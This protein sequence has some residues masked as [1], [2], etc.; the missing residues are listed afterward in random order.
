MVCDVTDRAS[1]R[2]AHQQAIS[3]FGKVLLL[4]ANAG[5]TAFDAMNG[6][7]DGDL[8]WMLAGFRC[9][10]GFRRGGCREEFSMRY[11]R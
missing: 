10:R 4:F 6:I 9:G 8:D 5:A 3:A 2:A 7:A 1:I 11:I